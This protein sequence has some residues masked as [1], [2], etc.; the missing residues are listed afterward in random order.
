M[1]MTTA[2]RSWCSLSEV[3]SVDSFSGSMGKIL[4]AV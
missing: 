1:S 2:T 3:R 4:A